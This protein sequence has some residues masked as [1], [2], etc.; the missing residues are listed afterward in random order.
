LQCDTASDLRERPKVLLP[1]DSF[2]V[3]GQN[4]P[5][6]EAAAVILIAELFELMASLPQ[7]ARRCIR[8]RMSERFDSYATL[9]F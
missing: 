1:I 6:S 2:V 7:A 9:R 8:R 4:V 5:M 3:R